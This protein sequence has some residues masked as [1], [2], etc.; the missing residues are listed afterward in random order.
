MTIPELPNFVLIGGPVPEVDNV[1][2][3]PLAGHEIG[4]SAWRT[5]SIE[6]DIN[7]K[8]V[9][10]IEFYLGLDDEKT[11]NLPEIY[12]GKH[13]QECYNL[14]IRHI[15]EIFCD[16]VGLYIFGASYLYAFDYLLAP[17]S[18]KRGVGYPDQRSR[19]D[20][21]KYGSE[22]LGIEVDKILFQSWFDDQS[23]DVEPILLS[24]VDAAVRRCASSVWDIVLELMERLQIPKNDR[25]A[26]D[27]VL[28][29]FMNGVP[30]GDGASLS[31]IITAG[32]RYMMN[33]NGMPEDVDDLRFAMLNELMLKSIEVSEYRLRVAI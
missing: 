24:V 14:G 7:L 31:E 6:S 3:L 13:L 33:H 16:F 21:L 32:W 11:R 29:H 22:Q 25:S 9:T 19:I 4:H 30:D 28:K 12:P 20:F 26:I 8:F 17:G 2:I 10:D 15:Q 1:L 5:H 23:G 18:T 27:R